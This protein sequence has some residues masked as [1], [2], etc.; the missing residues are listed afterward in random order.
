MLNLNFQTVL[1]LLRFIADTF[2]Q[3]L[4]HVCNIEHG[5]DFYKHEHTGHGHCISEL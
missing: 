4:K 1:I 2:I 5:Y 3:Y